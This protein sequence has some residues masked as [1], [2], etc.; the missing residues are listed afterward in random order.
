MD[1]PSKKYVNSYK[2]R[3]SKMMNMSYTSI[4]V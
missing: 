4:L 3:I 2:H 1:I